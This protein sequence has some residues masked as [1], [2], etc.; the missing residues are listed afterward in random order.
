MITERQFVRS[1][2]DDCIEVDVDGA[3]DAQALAAALRRLSSLS[4]VVAGMSSVAVQFDLAVTARDDV[5]SA[6]IALQAT[7]SQRDVETAAAQMQIAVHYDGPDL[8]A[9][10]DTLGLPVAEFV[11]IHTATLHSVEMLG[12]TPGFA[13]LSHLGAKY[14]VARLSSPRQHVAAGS[15]GFA[16]GRTGL[17]ALSGP[18]GW[19]LIG[20]TTTSLFDGHANEPFLIQAGMNIRFVSVE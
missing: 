9:V 3:A 1:L 19:P 14:D 17:Y 18:G 16:G 10:C 11:A 15:I 20:R 2:G 6:V 12:F 4:C 8:E 13:Y 5:V 7:L